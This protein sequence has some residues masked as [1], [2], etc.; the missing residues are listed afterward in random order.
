MTV[1]TTLFRRTLFLAAI[2][3][4]AALPATAQ[5]YGR[6]GDSTVS[7]S[8]GQSEQFGQD[9]TVLSGR[10]GRFFVPQ[11]EA[12]IGMEFWR[13]ASPSIYKVVPE[14]RYVS[15]A[16]QTFKPYAAVFVS[17][18]FYSNDV[19]SHNSFGV[20]GGMYYVMDNSTYLGFGLVHERQESCDRTVMSDCNQTKP[21]VTLHFR[22]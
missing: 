3:L 5:Y 12:S 22:F 20:R 6:G 16:G 7:V 1:R 21:E 15:A 13:G 11:F 19:A 8:L 9:Y 17:R 2:L 4:A 18:T 14:L 10:Y